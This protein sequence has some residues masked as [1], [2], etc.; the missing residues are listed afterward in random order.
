MY[1]M[2]DMKNINL[3][4]A[5]LFLILF[6]ASILTYMSVQVLRD[7]QRSALVDLNLL[8]P[9]L[10]NA[11]DQIMNHMIQV[12]HSDFDVVRVML[13]HEGKFVQPKVLPLTFGTLG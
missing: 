9:R 10:Q 2:H 8:V 13:D 4:W 11:F 1:F 3:K 5:A 12:S 7:A 6:P